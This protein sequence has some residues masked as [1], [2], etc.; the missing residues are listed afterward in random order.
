MSNNLLSFTEQFDNAYWQKGRG[1]IV[2]NATT[3]PYGGNTADKLVED[4]T[5]GQHLVYIGPVD[6]TTMPDNQT[7]T[8]SFHLKAAERTWAKVE[9]FNKN[10]NAFGI[11]VN[12]TTGVVG[13]TFGAQLLSNSVTDAGNGWWRASVTGSTSSGTNNLWYELL[14]ETADNTDTYAGDGA[15]GIYVW[16]AQLEVGSLSS[17]EAVPSTANLSLPSLG[18]GTYQQICVG[19]AS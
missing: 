3:A 19:F 8:L 1:S 6:Y 7:R 4:A 14:A 2:A 16:G 12:L 10:G 18:P 15:S 5:S 9:V 11:S 17:Y 13:A